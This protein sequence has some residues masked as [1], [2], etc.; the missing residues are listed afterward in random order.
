MC[1]S[2]EKVDLLRKQI[3]KMMT[4]EMFL[5]CHINYNLSYKKLFYFFNTF[6]SRSID[7]ENSF[8]I[9]FA[10]NDILLTVLL[11]DILFIVSVIASTLIRPF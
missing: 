11:I 10:S 1:I 3:M 8:E 2:S 7:F 5:N 4:N 6:C 9:G